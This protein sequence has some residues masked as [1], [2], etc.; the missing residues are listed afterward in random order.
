M[1][2][3]TIEVKPVSKADDWRERIAE[4]QRSGLSIKRFCQDQG[5]AEHRFYAWRRRLREC[6]AVRFALVD[7]GSAPR[8]SATGPCLEIVLTS[9][10][11]VRVGAGVEAA[12]LRVVLEAL[13]G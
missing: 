8:K 5:I 7:R 13:R 3:S 9:G 2:E 6:A 10:E 4:Q 11:T 1:I 12:T